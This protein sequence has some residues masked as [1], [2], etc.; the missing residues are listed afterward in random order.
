MTN[1]IEIV[2][3]RK[4]GDDENYC[5]L[6]V[7]GA[8]EATTAQQEIQKEVDEDFDWDNGYRNEKGEQIDAEE[9]E[10]WDHVIY[11][12]DEY[13][14]EDGQILAHNG[15]KF[16]VRIEEVKSLTGARIRT[17]VKDSNEVERGLVEIPVGWLATVREFC[18]DSGHYTVVW[19]ND[20]EGRDMG[21]CLWTEEEIRRDAE[22]VKE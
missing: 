9:A 16:R 10:D 12:N 21:W 11:V 18:P 20:A 5:Y 1:R 2:N 13:L 6:G 17:R 7:Y 22:E 8:D 14:F 19:D 3:W 4:H 15:R